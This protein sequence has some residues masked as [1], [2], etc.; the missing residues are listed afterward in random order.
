MANDAVATPQVAATSR[1]VSFDSS[2]LW[3]D[4]VK[5]LDTSRLERAGSALPGVYTL[6]V[7]LNDALVTRERIAFRE[8]GATR[9][10]MP[11]LTGELLSRLRIK[12][13]SESIQPNQCVDL[14]LEIPDARVSYDAGELRLD[15]SVPQASLMGSPR[16]YV[17]PSLWD[18]GVPAAYAN[19]DFNTFHYSGAGGSSTSNSLNVN[20]G[21]N[22]GPWRFRYQGYGQ[23]NSSPNTHSWQTSSA[24]LQRDIPGTIAR[25]RVGKANTNG[26]YFDSVGLLG[27][28]VMT[29]DRM[30]PDSQRGY[31]PVIQ[32]IA[33]SNARVTVRQAGNV[34]YETTVAPGPFRIDDLYSTGYSGNLDVTI[35]E[36]DGRKKTMIVPYSYAP[37]ALRAGA[38]RYNVD[39]GQVSDNNLGGGTKP[40]LAQATIQHGFNNVVSAY[41]GVAA[42]GFYVAGLSGIALNT[43]IGAFSADVTYA[44]TKLRDGPS[45]S[46]ASYRIQYSNFVQATGTSFSI[47][48]YRYSTSGYFSLRDAIAAQDRSI[49]SANLYRQ[50]SQAQLTINQ[51]LQRYGQVYAT[52]SATN[53]WNRPG[54]DTQYQIGYSKSLARVTLQITAART[55][56]GFGKTDNQVYASVSLPLGR[57][58]YAPRLMVSG[59]KASSGRDSAAVSLS[60][61]LDKEA[62]MSYSINGTY[63]RA[64][65]MSSAASAI[66]ANFAYMGS[67]GQ[68]RVSGA[69]GQ[70]YTNVSGGVSGSIVVHPGG[71]TLG[72]PFYDAAAIIAAPGGAGA[73]VPYANGLRLDGRGY[74]VVPYLTPYRMNSI[75]VDPKGLPL[76][77]EFKNTRVNVAPT[78]GAIV[79]AK[80]DVAEGRAAMI[81]MTDDHGK[82]VPFGAEVFDDKGNS[83]GVAGQ[84]GNVFVRGV[85]ESGVLKLKWGQGGADTCVS[86]YSLPKR[87]K[88]DGHGYLRIET[89]CASSG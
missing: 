78:D 66:N 89:T 50:R 11:C 45:M 21:A 46:G 28:S 41:G 75:E 20:A 60:G 69:Q 70:G 88:H 61:Q 84:G 74:A 6:D 49:G 83:V 85:A 63:N 8:T 3:G 72:Q 7:Y 14:E 59:T 54:T 64:T 68:V 77:V 10:V 30:L 33:E 17:D 55:Q 18:N 80:F 26:Q 48:A 79:M 38:T 57:R 12:L 39:V 22:A 86:P 13:P 34:V 32:G 27:A 47:G 37:N 24:Y 25:A 16:G 71:V 4:S 73:E 53:F 42:T 51:D 29:D 15:L 40:F 5:Q 58:S 35:T 2:M 1:K 81:H 76:D 56:N 82:P 43:A 44:N 65:G 36:A 31:A 62:R 9:K 52:A 23:A 87:G 19:Y 67:K